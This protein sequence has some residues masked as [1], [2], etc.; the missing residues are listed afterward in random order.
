VI[1]NLQCVVLDCPDALGLAHFY[2]SLLG[3]T[4]NHLADLGETAEPGPDEHC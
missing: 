4:V 1:A 2:Q 3:G